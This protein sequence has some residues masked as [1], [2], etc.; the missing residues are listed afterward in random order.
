LVDPGANAVN[1][2]AVKTDLMMMVIGD[3]PAGAD[4]I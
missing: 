2:T 4:L 1:T 3:R